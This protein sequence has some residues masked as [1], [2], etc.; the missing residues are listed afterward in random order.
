MLEGQLSPA[1]WR[2]SLDRVGPSADAPTGVVGQGSFDS[3]TQT[4]MG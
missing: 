4:G 3:L 1:R 2:L